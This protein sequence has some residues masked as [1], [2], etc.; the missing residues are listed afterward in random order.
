M[1]LHEHVLAQGFLEFVKASGEG[2][3]F[4]RILGRLLTKDRSDESKA[5]TTHESA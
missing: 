2:P 5:A 4:Y 1:P 3:L